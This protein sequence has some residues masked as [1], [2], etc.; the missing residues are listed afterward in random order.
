MKVFQSARTS[1]RS[2]E[3]SV[4]LWKTSPATKFDLFL[5]RDTYEANA[6][7]R[8]V[9]VVSCVR[10]N[11]RRTN[12]DS[13]S[14]VRAEPRWMCD[15]IA[16]DAP[17]EMA[18]WNDRTTAALW[19]LAFFSCTTLFFFMDNTRRLYKISFKGKRMRRRGKRPRFDLNSFCTIA[20]KHGPWQTC[21][22]RLHGTDTDGLLVRSFRRLAGRLLLIEIFFFFFQHQSDP[23]AFDG[24]SRNCRRGRVLVGVTS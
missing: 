16:R 24:T 21:I 5:Q 20:A 22:R 1:F 18:V 3:S 19:S 6:H 8:G 14:H 17:S 12:D 23:I 11:G 7:E 13:S 9:P 2:I 15:V 10:R 4:E